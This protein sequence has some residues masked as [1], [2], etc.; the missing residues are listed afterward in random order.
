MERARELDVWNHEVLQEIDALER[1]KR[2]A[3]GK[4][5]G[6]GSF[7]GMFS[8][9]GSKDDSGSGTSKSPQ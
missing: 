2:K 9:T 6:K 7:S 4:E 3:T 5:K 8:S 1:L